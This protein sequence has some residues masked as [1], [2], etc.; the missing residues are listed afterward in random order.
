MERALGSD[1]DESPAAKL[2]KLRTQFA[3]ALSDEESLFLLADLLSVPL[4]PGCPRAEL[5]A[6]QR[7][8]KMLAVLLA[9]GLNLAAEMPVLVIFEDVHWSDPTSL[10]LLNLGIE[11]VTQARMLFVITCRPEFVPP[12]PERPH[13]TTLALK[14]LNKRDSSALAQ[15]VAGHNL[16]PGA[17]TAE[18]LTRADGV[19]LFITELTKGLLE[20]G[21]LREGQGRY[22]LTRPLP[23]ATIPTTLRGLF[24]ARLDRLGPAKEV[25]QTGAAIG[26]EFSYDLLSR[27]VTLPREQLDI[28]LVHLMQ[29]ELLARRELEQQAVYVFTH[30]L[31]RDAAYAGLLRDRRIPLHAAI[32][33][34]HEES[35]QGVV[36]TQPETLARHLTEAQHFDRAASYWL[37]AG[38][39]AEQRS[40]LIE[41]IAHL[42]AGLAAVSELPA[43]AGRDRLELDLQLALG[44]CMIATQG[45]AAKAA[46]ATFSRARELCAGARRSA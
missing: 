11:H 14:R 31:V 18:I 32:A 5:S 16:L 44:P 43:G 12:W 28:A 38:R 20:S 42:Q 22:V 2:A 40:A 19:P 46:V 27:V 39:L 23:T 41:A 24:L 8:E 29:A 33:H 26:R 37:K 30:A 17:V 10:E 15:R 6:Q 25:A 45:P 36:E 3:G 1:P 34:A 7:K 4:D 21:F 35:W 9:Q 13:I